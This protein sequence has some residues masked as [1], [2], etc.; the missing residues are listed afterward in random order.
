MDCRLV[1]VLSG[2]GETYSLRDGISSVGR[3]SDNDIQLMSESV[4]RHHAQIV[5]LPNVCEVEDLGSTNG[6]LLNGE[7]VSKEVVRH[8][9]EIRMG[10]FILRFEA[11]SSGSYQEL[12]SGSRDYSDRSQHDTIRIRKRHPDDVC[13]CCSTFCF[14]FRYN[15]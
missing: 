13:C 3:E 9:D 1:N 7:V 11:L 15:I 6:T 5:N 12:A 14:C 4:S 2:V 10:E 8:G